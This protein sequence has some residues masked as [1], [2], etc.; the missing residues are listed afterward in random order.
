M[1]N[2]K[3]LSFLQELHDGRLELKGY[4][5]NMAQAKAVA[6]MLPMIRGLETLILFDNGLSDDI[7]ALLTLAAFMNPNL[8]KL[9]IEGISNKPKQCTCNTLK[10]LV[11]IFPK[12]L[13]GLSF[14]GVSEFGIHA[15]RTLT[16]LQNPEVTLRELDLSR[17]TLSPLICAGVG[18]LLINSKEL[19]TLEL[20]GARLSGYS[21]SIILDGLCRNF[22]LQSLN[23]SHNNLSSGQT[24]ECAI[25]ITQVIARHESLMHVDLSM[26]GLAKEEVIF[27]GMALA[28]SR[29]MLALHLSGNMLE[30]Y[31]RIFLRTLLDAKVAA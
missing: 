13:E 30:Y 17:Q 3:P 14:S 4:G 31:E 21:A 26:C 10:A 22:G 6:C 12:K 20:L 19:R 7:A 29:S 18:A 15:A 23:L 25:K 16:E 8:R 28:E 1:F 5:L 27:I 11:A 9:G 24:H 2:A